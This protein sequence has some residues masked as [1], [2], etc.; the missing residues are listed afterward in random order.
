MRCSYAPRSIWI[1]ACN[2][3]RL[4]SSMLDAVFICGLLLIS[5]GKGAMWQ[6]QGNSDARE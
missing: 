1:N 2:A 4:S 5:L 3:I 6:G